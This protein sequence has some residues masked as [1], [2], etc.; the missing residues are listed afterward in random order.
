MLSNGQNK[1]FGNIG[2]TSGSVS[3]IEI[4][5]LFLRWWKK[6]VKFLSGKN[7]SIWQF[8]NLQIK[9]IFKVKTNIQS[10]QWSWK[11]M[12]ETN[13]GLANKFSFMSLFNVTAAA[14]PARW[15]G[16]A[17]TLLSP[18]IP[19]PVPVPDPD[20]VQVPQVPASQPLD[21]KTS[22]KFLWSQSTNL[23]RN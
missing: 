5:H 6:L 7:M 18:N 20:P 2:Y 16:A 8:W 13:W 10:I 11:V 9:T 19:V 23:I 1:L 17:A 21:K 15:P 12:S 3:R 14:A 4:R 22:F